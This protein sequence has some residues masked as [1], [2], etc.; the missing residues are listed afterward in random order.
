MMDRRQL[1]DDFSQRVDQIMEHQDEISLLRFDARLKN[2]TR[3]SFDYDSERFD[4]ASRPARPAGGRHP[5]SVFDAVVDMIASLVTLNLL[6]VSGARFVALSGGAFAC[7]LLTH[8]SFFVFFSTSAVYHLF[9]ESHARTVKVLSMVRMGLLSLSVMLITD[10]MCLVCGRS[11]MLTFPVQLFIAAL[12]VFFTS[13]STR[14]GFRAAS[15]AHCLA[16]LASLA[17][18]EP[19]AYGVTVV[20]LGVVSGLVPALVPTS[21]SRIVRAGRTIG[22]FHLVTVIAFFQMVA[23]HQ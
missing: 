6:I 5:V 1:F 19:D 3:F 12:S 20:V 23:M 21:G 8:V 18:M 7:V 16:Y 4:K 10:S 17:F 9:D 13:L 2:G 15:L 22:L 14:G 11:S